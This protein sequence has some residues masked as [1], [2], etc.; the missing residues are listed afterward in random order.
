MKTKLFCNYCNGTLVQRLVEGK[1]RQVCASC[2]QIYYENPLPAVSI[3]VANEERELLLVKRAQEPAK[4]MWCF[5]IGFAESGESIEDAAMR[6]LKEEAGIDGKIVQIVD[7]TSE[8]NDVYGDVLVVSFEA[9]HV[10]GIASGGDD[11][12][13]A[14]YF[15]I[16]NLPKLAFPSQDKALAKFIAAKK[17]TWSMTDSFQLLVQETTDGDHPSVGR[18]L[19]D[20]LVK[21]I[22]ENAAR[23]VGLWLDDI[24]TN[25][26][27]KS[28]QAYNRGELSS[29]AALLISEFARWIR[30]DKNEA[31]LKRF[32]SDL[33]QR[34]KRGKIPL[35]EIVSAISLLKKH[36]FRFTSSAGVWYRPVDIYKVVELSE[37]LV[38][39]FDHVSYYVVLGYGK[40]SA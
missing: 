18:L 34:R 5:P 9:E 25:P 32:Y 10:S 1:E 17:D 19:S 16:A 21:T 14:R 38:Y 36:V 22:E 20:E 12:V 15:P 6:E 4:D 2:G 37:R 35:E 28:Y 27:T 40:S 13:D 11:A 7:V 23:I 30:G 26:S 29:D 8:E 33:G 39:F 3:I 31:E 24:S